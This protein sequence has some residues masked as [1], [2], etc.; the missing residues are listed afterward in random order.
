VEDGTQDG[1]RQGTRLPSDSEVDE[2]ELEERESSPDLV[3]LSAVDFFS[4]ALQNAQRQLSAAPRKCVHTS[5]HSGKSDRTIRRHKKAKRDLEA[6]GF[7]SL[8]EFFR[9]KDESTRQRAIGAVQSEEEHDEH[10]EGHKDKATEEEHESEDKDE[11]IGSARSA[12]GGTASMC[13]LEEG[14]KTDKTMEGARSAEG[15]MTSMRV[16]EEEEEEPDEADKT[17]ELEGTRGPEGGMVSIHVLEEEE[18]ETDEEDP[19][20]PEKVIKS[21]WGPSRTI[22][23]ESEESSSSSCGGDTPWSDLEDLH[24]TGTRELEGLCHGNAP[25]DTATEQPM[26][27]A[28]ELLRDRVGLQAAQGELSRALKARSGTGSLDAVLRDRVACHESDSARTV[29]G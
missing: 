16:F 21:S 17:M 24:S 28:A 1:T 27:N 20:D 12:E 11:V 3:E 6:Q 26:D 13:V 2:P 9:Q 29:S 8:A 7:F 19:S 4:S 23:Y 14:D 18:S 22:L 10:N 15:S 25:D 5:H